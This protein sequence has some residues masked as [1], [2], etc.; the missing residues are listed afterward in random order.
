MYK[1]LIVWALSQE[2]NIV[3]DEIKKLSLRNIK[4]SFLTTWVGNYNMILNLTRFLEQNNDFDFIVNIWVCG[5]IPPSQ[6]SPPREEGV[7][8]IIQIA[9]ILN[10]SN[11]KELIIPKIL[12]F[13]ELV[14]IACSENVIY[15][16][17][18]LLDELYV[19][20]ESYW[21]EKVC[22]SFSFPRIILKLPVDKVWEETKKFDFDKA[23]KS[24]S[25]NI[26]YKLLFDKIYN[27][28]ENTFSFQRKIKEKEVFEKYK[29]YFLFT[30]SENEIF[31]RLYY[32]Y[33]ALVN[34]DFDIF[35][36]DNKELSKKDFI[37]K[38]DEY[39]EWFLIK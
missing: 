9:R 30:F 4:T 21:F 15:D 26:D 16:K 24:L 23:K 34:D 31:K 25:Q 3:R 12:D 7:A 11:S 39:L 27:Y 20:M 38:L 28:L 33:L 29:E 36:S 17:N 5:Y 35:F 10:L 8:Q 37:M 22:D 6:P 14:S 19:D 1:I 13:W 2:I 18:D 32:R